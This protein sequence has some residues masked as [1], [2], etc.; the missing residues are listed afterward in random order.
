M[1]EVMFMVKMVLHEA[2]A[3][4]Y[5][6]GINSISWPTYVRD[7]KLFSDYDHEVHDKASFI[8]NP[9]YQRVWWIGINTL[10]VITL[11]YMVWMIINIITR[12]LKWTPIKT[13]KL[14]TDMSKLLKKKKNYFAQMFLTESSDWLHR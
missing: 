12:Y 8:I 9:Y 10:S 13:Y 1:V 3:S 14:N 2:A 4:A 11:K 6:A 5:E 7:P